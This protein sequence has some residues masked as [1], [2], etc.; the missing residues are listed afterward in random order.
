MSFFP[1]RGLAVPQNHLAGLK[2]PLWGGEEGKGGR[3]RKGKEGNR[4]ER[5]PLP[6]RT[7]S[8]YALAK[9]GVREERH[10]HECQASDESWYASWWCLQ[11]R[12]TAHSS[13][14]RYA[15]TGSPQHTS[16]SMWQNNLQHST[17]SLSILWFIIGTFFQQNIMRST[18]IKDMKKYSNTNQNTNKQKNSRYQRIG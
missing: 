14:H 16:C 7:I 17:T 4:R 2:G 8:C 11:V 15:S 5:T 1:A 10:V 13:A 6:H 3:E 18:Q 12:S 9:A